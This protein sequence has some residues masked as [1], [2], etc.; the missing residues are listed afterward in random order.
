MNSKEKYVG[1]KRNIKKQG[2]L[3]YYNTWKDTMMGIDYVDVR[4]IPC[5]CFVCLRK[6]D[7]P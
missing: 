6:M 7:Y 5:R 1:F 3:F 4:H 2:F